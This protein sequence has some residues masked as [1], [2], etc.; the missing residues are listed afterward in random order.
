MF[1]SL[2][3]QTD[4]RVTSIAR[5]WLDRPEALRAL[6]VADRLCCSG[7]RQLVRFRC[8]PERRPHFAHR[9]LLDCPLARRSAEVLEAQA[10]VYEWLCTKYPGKVEL[11]VDLQTEGWKPF[12]DLVVRPEG[13]K[14][15]VY[16]IF[17]RQQRYRDA[18]LF[19]VHREAAEHHFIH[20]QTTLRPWPGGLLDLTASQRDFT[21]RTL[22]DEPF[23]PWGHLSFLDTQKRELM[24]CRGLRCVHEPNIFSAEAVRTGPLARALISPTTGEL[25]FADD[26]EEL[27]A[28]KARLAEGRVSKTLELPQSGLWTS[29]AAMR[30]A[31][32]RRPESD[33]EA[34]PLRINEPMRC[35]DCGAMTTEWSVAHPAQGTC[36]CRAC[37]ARRYRGTS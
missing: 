32:A 20:T 15:F 22:Y 8:G 35:E 34:A 37:L 26:V 14:P 33:G 6:A 18:L 23:R 5:E 2:N 25:H 16:W 31:L 7:C 17:D 3:N 24:V 4:E 21:R 27:Q 30:D 11:D 19:G 12:A 36:V 29:L 1:V 13:T 28:W 10:Q 9:H